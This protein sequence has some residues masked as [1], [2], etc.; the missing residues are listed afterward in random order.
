MTVYSE[1]FVR[2]RESYKSRPVTVQLGGN[3][4]DRNVP[5]LKIHRQCS[6][7]LLTEVSMTQP[8][9]MKVKGSEADFTTS[10]ELNRGG[11]LLHMIKILILKKQPGHEAVHSRPSSAKVMNVWSYTSTSPQIFIAW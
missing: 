8:Y 2:A 7:V 11:T 9:Q 1:F 4:K 3:G 5:D 10:K 6:F